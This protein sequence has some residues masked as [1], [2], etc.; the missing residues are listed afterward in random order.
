V[1]EVG[2]ISVDLDAGF[3]LICA[4]RVASDVVAAVQD[5]DFQPQFRGGAFR[6]GQAKKTR[7]DYDEISVHNSPVCFGGRVQQPCLPGL[8]YPIRFTWP[9]MALAWPCEVSGGL[10]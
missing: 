6:D 7:T 5:S 4:V 9:L 8:D 2:A 10:R 3:G 1:E